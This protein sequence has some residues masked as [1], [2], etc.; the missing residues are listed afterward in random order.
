LNGPQGTPGLE[1]RLA[2]LE[3]IAAALEG[4]RLELEDAMGLFEEGIA[5][6]REAE[7]LLSQVELRIERVLVE[8]DGRLATEPIGE[9]SP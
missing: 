1:Q 5:H 8:A 7:R 3:A 6:L 9:P 4:D 2:R